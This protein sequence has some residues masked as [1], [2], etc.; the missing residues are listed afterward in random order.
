[1]TTATVSAFRWKV[2]SAAFVVAVFAWGTGFYGPSIFL[3]AL[4]A[5][6]GWPIA[7]LSTAVT[8]HF[9]CSAALVA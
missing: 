6:R 2:V 9:L 3:Q 7:T 8:A 1:M 4:H 5:G